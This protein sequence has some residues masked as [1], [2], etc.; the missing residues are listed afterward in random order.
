MADALS[1]VG[2]KP[3]WA[4][5]L[6]AVAHAAKAHWRYPVG[7][8]VAWQEALTVSPEAIR[9]APTFAGLWEGR[10][11][12]FYRLILDSDTAVLDHLWILPKFMRRGFGREL[13][14]HAE[15]LA[16]NA[17]AASIEIESDPHAT[18]FYNA[19][20]AHVVDYRSGRIDGIERRLPLL[21]KTLVPHTSSEARTK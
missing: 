16:R 12:G 7:W 5:C 11:V 10:I 20:G 4:W 6:T 18:A 2:A 15:D 19:C 17:Q 21:R 9:A 3:E 14:H 1:I 13:F 8:L